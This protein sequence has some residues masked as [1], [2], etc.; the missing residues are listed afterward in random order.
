MNKIIS[1]DTVEIMM[2]YD[3][4]GNVRELENVVERMIVTG[5]D[6]LS[7][8]KDKIGENV[9]ISDF[10]RYKK[11]LEEYDKKLLLSAINEEG[12]VIKASEKLGIDPTTIRR[13]LHR[14]NVP[15]SYWA[16]N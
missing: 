9:R 5:E 2:N 11:C 16:R 4:P 10:E 3:W 12:S 13:K 7:I 1:K 6:C 15:K 14:Y 8:L